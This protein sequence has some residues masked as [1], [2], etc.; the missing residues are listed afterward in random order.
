MQKIDYAE[1]LGF[2]AVS[3]QLSDGVDFQDETVGAKVAGTEPD[4]PAK[5]IKDASKVASPHQFQ[6]HRLWSAP[7]CVT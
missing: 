4:D 3:D 5:P 6:G 7:F 2:A 1:L